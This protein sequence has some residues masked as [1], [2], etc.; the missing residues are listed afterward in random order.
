[1][2]TPGQ[3]AKYIYFIYYQIIKNVR[4]G[5]QSMDVHFF[6]VPRQ[7]G[8][9]IAIVLDGERIGLKNL[10]ASE[11]RTALSFKNADGSS[12]RHQSSVQGQDGY[13]FGLSPSS[14]DPE[15]PE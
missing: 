3:D 11:A 6:K 8:L 15:A 7:P 5:E 4:G 9:T 13:I 1:M 10:S 14:H 2:Q 12:G